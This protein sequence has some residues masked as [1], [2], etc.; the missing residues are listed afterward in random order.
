MKSKGEYTNDI[1]IVN[2]DEIRKKRAAKAW[3]EADGAVQH[4]LYKNLWEIDR[5]VVYEFTQA[6][7]GAGIKI[8]K[9]HLHP[10][11]QVRL[12]ASI[13]YMEYEDRLAFIEYVITRFGYDILNAEYAG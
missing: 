5:E 11:R 4:A 13:F 9:L 3:A 2:I 8:P 1:K 6:P 12:F 10:K 7:E